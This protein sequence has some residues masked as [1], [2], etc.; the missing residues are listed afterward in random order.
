MEWPMGCSSRGPLSLTIVL[1][2]REMAV[3][4]DFG[5]GKKLVREGG[6]VRW[7]RG[8]KIPLSRSQSKAKERVAEGGG[9]GS[10]HLVVSFE[11]QQTCYGLSLSCSSFPCRGKP[12][13]PGPMLVLPCSVGC[14]FREWQIWPHQKEEGR[15]EVPVVEGGAKSPIGPHSPRGG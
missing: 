4:S 11:T 14:K 1:W 13:E 12:W 6:Q 5:G 3:T 8:V 10:S 2:F 9:E 15:R 7:Q